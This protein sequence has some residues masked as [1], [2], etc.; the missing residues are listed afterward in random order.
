MSG[1]DA[2]P[3]IQPDH[4]VGVLLVHGIGR[5]GRGASLVE[6]GEAIFRWTRSWLHST[7]VAEHQPSATRCVVESVVLDRPAE[8]GSNE[9]CLRF[10]TNAGP[11]R[12]LMVEAHWADSFVLPDFTTV[13]GWS[14]KVLPYAAVSSIA[15]RVRL[16]WRA[17]P[18]NW[19]KRALA[20]VPWIF[21]WFISPPIVFTVEIILALL[22]LLWRIPIPALRG[23]F[24]WAFLQIAEVLGDSYVFNES[25]FRRE[26]IV[27]SVLR[28]M[29]NLATRCGHLVVLAHSQGAAVAAAAVSQ[30]LPEQLR[31]FVTYGSG[32]QRLEELTPDEDEATT[33]FL[34]R[35]IIAAML[36]SGAAFVSLVWAVLGWY[37]WSIPFARTPLADTWLLRWVPE[38]AGFLVGT[39]P[40]PSWIY[41]VLYVFMTAGLAIAAS[42]RK[43]T[44]DSFRSRFARLLAERKIHW[45]DLY[46]THDPVPNGPM[47]AAEDAAGVESIEVCNYLSVFRDHTHYH[48]NDE[49]FVSRVVTGISRWASKRVPLHELTPLDDTVLQAA[50][51]LRRGR[52]GVSRWGRRLLFFS[53]LTLAFSPA[54]HT[55]VGSW[56]A[57]G[58][59]ASKLRV[60]ELPWFLE[61]I[62]MLP[63]SVLTAI[64]VGAA[65]FLMIALY[66]A[67]HRAVTRV[68]AGSIFGRN[69]GTA[70]AQMQ[71]TALVHFLPG[72]AVAAALVFGFP[73]V[74]PL[75]SAHVS[76]MLYGNTQLD[77][78]VTSA[79]V[80][81]V[82]IISRDFVVLMRPFWAY[83]KVVRNMSAKGAQPE[84]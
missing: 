78:F 46:A 76:L 11:V 80:V 45:M 7:S 34:E 81:A 27:G 8:S 4:E 58:V 2:E 12:W 44:V 14:M 51:T 62:E 22:A 29:R 84:R 52:I 48:E 83:Q 25:P 61:I 37:G 30:E 32:L 28:Q 77:W 63:P 31:L 70:G 21:L 69:A 6:V 33:D 9:A 3:P 23:Y 73:S 64:I 66:D 60:Q 56:T 71:L 49:E 1:Y 35:P 15:R 17:H 26:A 39:A 57:R 41:L 72:S 74:P 55:L 53:A 79:T 59:A 65:Y 36:L 43:R 5:Q 24:Q 42:P 82:A 38:W 40:M 67:G 20:C 68:H 18:N 47:F 75:L 19:I 50:S 13:A 10:E 54:V 16:A